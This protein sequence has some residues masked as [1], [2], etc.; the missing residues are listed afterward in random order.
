MA[1]VRGRGRLL[2][3]GNI[4][5]WFLGISAAMTMLM[6]SIVMMAAISIIGIPIAVFLAAAP[7]LFVVALGTRIISRWL[8]GG[9][10]AVVAGA[11]VTL[12]L[13]AIPPFLI[14]G[15]LEGRAK[16]FVREDHDDG[17]K[18][19]GE[20]IAVRGEAMTVHSRDTVNCD[21]FCQRALVNGITKRI[22]VVKQ[23]VSLPIDPTT[24]VDSF[25]MERRTTCPQVKLSEGRDPIKIDGERKDKRAY[26]L[27]QLEIAKGNCLIV[28]TA[29]LG[30]ADTIVSVGVVNRGENAVTAGL[31]LLADTVSADRITVHGKAGPAYKETFRQTYVVTQKLMPF[32]VPTVTGDTGLTMARALA[33]YRETINVPSRYYEK[34]DWSG[35]L[36]ARM[37]YDL[38]LRAGETQNE[39]RMVLKEAM[40]RQ[41]LD[42]TAA[43][44]GSDF[45]QG[46][47]VNQ[48]IEGDDLILAQQL[49]TDE[50]FPVPPGAWT[51]V[52]YTK[53][54]RPDYFD[55]IGASM[56]ARL[57]AFA[58]EDDRD[59]YVKWYDQAQNVGSVINVLPRETI[60][61]HR[62]DLEWLARQDVLR[63]WVHAALRR[64]SEFGAT[65][66]PTLLWLI[67][68]AQRFRD[69]PR[70]EDWQHPYIAGLVGL[71]YLR[72]EGAAMIQPLYDRLD[73][74]VVSNRGS[75]GALAI[76]TLIGMGATPED[77]WLHVK[78]AERDPGKMDDVRRA[79][80]KTVRDAQKKA[81]CAY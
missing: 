57:R 34:P 18:P 28:E 44:V 14:N 4:W 8:G 17:T 51:V 42:A 40:K 32:Y 55:A 30:M 15:S 5:L 33:R 76:N 9:L 46:F 24:E 77:V 12:A 43:K 58:A 45:M 79:F 35:F 65:G 22:L 61:R 80:D 38:A 48:K 70:S 47:A 75:Y 36:T 49:M 7:F 68:D 19:A 54:A 16:S 53:A 41:A 56:F 29:P 81:D 26:E 52:K 1:G 71:C 63:V 13:L 67:D 74:G 66:A 2:R 3:S 6:P 72:M 59:K 39:T 73:S 31:S 60:L 11:A 62:H 78:P 50:R 37:G 69:K 10:L 23:D 64:L 21:G 25:R 27:M 20:V